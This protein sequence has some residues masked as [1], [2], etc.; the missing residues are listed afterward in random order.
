MVRP[1]GDYR[2]QAAGDWTNNGTWQRYN[3]TAWV[4]ATDY[5]GEA[6]G[7]GAVSILNNVTLNVSPA[8]SLGSLSIQANLTPNNSDRAL[9]IQGGLSVSSGTLSLSN[10]NGRE[11]IIS[12]AGS[13]AMTGGVITETADSYGEIIF[14]GSAIQSFTKTGGTISNDIRF[15]VNSEGQIFCMGTSVLDGSSGTFILNAGATLTT[16]HQDGISSS[17]STGSIQ[18]SG[19]RSFSTAANYVY[20]G[21][22]AQVTGSG[23][24]ATVNNLTVSNAAGVTLTSAVTVSNQLT[25][26]SGS[27][28]VGANTL[29]LNGPAIAGTPSNL[30]TTSSS[31]LVFG[32]S[33][34]GINIPS[35][36]TDLNNLTINNTSGVTMNSSLTLASGGTLT[37]TSGLLNTGS[38]IIAVTN[39]S[40]AAIAYT[41]GSFVNVTTG[42][43]QR[44]LA[45]GLWRD[46]I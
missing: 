19:T 3:G 9:I 44:T 5:P 14:N 22:S 36:V 40:A 35:S 20:N 13:F 15:T 23:L 2:T 16:A 46:R 18:V 8:N 12:L 11:L 1:P 17:G 31:S 29:S 25:L 45:S 43:L 30:S 26:S 4:N 7:T 24:P 37:L 41:A 42:A 27:F 10:N 33:S 21:T 28:V 32:G 39:T 34:S 38:N 6:T